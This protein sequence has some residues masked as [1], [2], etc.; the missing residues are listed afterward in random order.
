MR[1]HDCTLARAAIL[2]FVTAEPSSLLRGCPACGLVQIQPAASAA[3]RAHCA[4]CHR[5]LPDDHD[6]AVARSRCAAIAAAAAVLYPVAISLP[7]LRIERLGHVHDAS[8]WS[9]AVA[10]LGGGQWLV[11]VVVLVCSLLLPAAKLL[12]LLAWSLPHHPPRG[13]RLLARLIELT[14]RWGMLDVLLVAVL[15]AT[16][17]LGALMEITAGPGALAFVV[18]VVLSLGAGACFEPRATWEESRAERRS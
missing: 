11:G 1:H 4:R 18:M 5:C 17:K 15:V 14:G 3:W 7:L 2:C 10:L 9:A 6:R 12:A 13:G 16:V 8:A